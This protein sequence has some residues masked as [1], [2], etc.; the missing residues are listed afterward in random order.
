MRDGKVWAR[1][2]FL[3][4]FLSVSFPPPSP[5]P[6]ILGDGLSFLCTCIE[7]LFENPNPTNPPPSV[8]K[9]KWISGNEQWGLGSGP[10]PSCR[11]RPV[12]RQRRRWHEPTA[13]R[14]AQGIGTK[15]GS[16]RQDT[17]PVVSQKVV[18]FLGTYILLL[19]RS[20]RCTVRGTRRGGN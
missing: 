7:N 3:K 1:G 16:S 10:P 6:L 12:G 19:L 18:S 8:C 15:H 11:R 17:T 4:S 2:H 13:R 5:L 20:S 14:K 9:I